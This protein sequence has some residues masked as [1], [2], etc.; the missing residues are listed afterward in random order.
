M[1][2][3]HPALLDYLAESYHADTL[4]RLET[5]GLPAARD[6][7]ETPPNARLRVRL[8]AFRIRRAFIQPPPS[9]G[10]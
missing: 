9:G 1:F 5:P 7:R 10:G 3:D 6:D 8:P 2:T 4:R